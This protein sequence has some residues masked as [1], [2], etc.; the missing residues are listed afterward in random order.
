MRIVLRKGAKNLFGPA[1][2][3]AREQSPLNLTQADLAELITSMGLSIDRSAISRIENQER[4]VNDIEM[5]YFQA[6]L[7]I[8]YN[9]L[10]ELYLRDASRL[11]AYDEFRLEEADISLRVAEFDP[12]G[13]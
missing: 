2:R 11:P 1:L 3:R 10:Y 13:E 8:N 4:T 9:R 6:A 12:E 5:Q 7:R